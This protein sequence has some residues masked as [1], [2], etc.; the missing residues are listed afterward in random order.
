MYYHAKNF[1]TALRGFYAKSY[2]FSSVDC[3]KYHQSVDTEV[4]NNYYYALLR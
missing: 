1:K 2:G 4:S 3:G